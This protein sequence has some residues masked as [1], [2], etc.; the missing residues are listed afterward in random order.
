MEAEPNQASQDE[1]MAERVAALVS[2]ELAK[3]KRGP[4]R[5]YKHKR[6][7]P[8][9]V[10]MQ[11]LY[12]LG[13]AADVPTRLMFFILY[14]TG[15]RISE[16]MMIRRRDIREEIVNGVPVVMVNLV[17]R[18][19]RKEP[20]R[21]VPIILNSKNADGL[22]L[23]EIMRL[24]ENAAFAPDALL[25]VSCKMTYE[26]MI[27]RLTANLDAFEWNEYGIRERVSFENFPLFCHFLRHC[28][29]SDL[30]KCYDYNAFELAKYMG[31]SDPRMAGTYIHLNMKDAVRKMV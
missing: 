6:P 10:S 23:D 13:M 22:M 9:P 27:K 30:V 21:E 17:T 14:L 8:E 28:R 5:D 15:A 11:E 12:D 2:K 19:N 3:H 1:A 29:A 4:S 25:F 20:Q 31:W 18:K 24:I 26:R 16:A 7:K